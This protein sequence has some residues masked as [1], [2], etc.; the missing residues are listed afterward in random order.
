LFPII[1]C[2]SAQPHRY[3]LLGWA[4]GLTDCPTATLSRAD[5]LSSRPPGHLT[6]PHLPSIHHRLLHLSIPRIPSSQR[7]A[8]PASAEL[9]SCCTLNGPQRPELKARA[10]PNNALPCPRP[11]VPL[12]HI[13]PFSLL[14]TH[15]ATLGSRALCRF[16]PFDSLALSSTAKHASRHSFVLESWEF[17]LHLRFRFRATSL[18]QAAC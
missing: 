13:L 2:S 1:H 14:H 3:S 4:S 7:H 5:T 6:P 12:P 11:T 15:V 18:S 9:L 17:L 16:H 8:Q 10:H